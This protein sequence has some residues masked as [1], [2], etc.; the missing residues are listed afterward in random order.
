MN[1]NT[2]IST[3][4]MGSLD[5]LYLNYSGSFFNE[6]IKN[7]QGSDIKIK[8]YPTISCYVFL[9]FAVNYFII[10]KNASPDDAFLLGLSIYAVF[11][12]TNHAIIDK[13][14]IKAVIIDSLWGGILFYLTTYLT[15]NIKKRPNSIIFR[16]VLNILYT[17]GIGAI[18]SEIPV[19]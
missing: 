9:V 2:V 5:A 8:I 6:V 1:I 18:P 17:L 12:L 10:S 19:V 16:S 11:D 7:I 14:P 4:I 15:Y 3:V 13:W